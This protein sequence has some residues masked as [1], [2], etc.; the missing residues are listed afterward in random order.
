MLLLLL[1]VLLLLRR[2]LRPL[3]HAHKALAQSAQLQQRLALL[4]IQPP[5]LPQV[6]GGLAGGGGRHEGRFHQHRKLR[7]RLLLRERPHRVERC[8]PSAYWR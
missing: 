6:D 7:I 2:L 1:R 3:A 4:R 5:R 8:I